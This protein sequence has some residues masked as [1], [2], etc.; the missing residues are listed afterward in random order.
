MIPG[1]CRHAS[2]SLCRHVEKQTTTGK[3]DSDAIVSAAIAKATI[4]KKKKDS[5]AAAK[6]R[7]ECLWAWVHDRIAAALDRDMV[8]FA[9]CALHHCSTFAL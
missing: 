8:R 9:D 5:N 1:D 4:S 7:E 2:L 6:A 3:R